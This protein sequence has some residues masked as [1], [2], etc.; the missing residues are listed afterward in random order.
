MSKL[1]LIT[2]GA[3]SGKSSFAL[4]LAKSLKGK[5]IYIA[6]ALPLDSEMRRRISLHKKARHK[7]WVTIE[8]PIDILSAIK[9]IRGKSS[10]IILDCLTLLLSNLML[11]GFN[12]KAIFNKIKSIT[13]V[14]KDKANVSIVVTNEVGSGIVPDNDLARRF[15]DLQGHANQIVNERADLVYLLVSGIPVRIKGEG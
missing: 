12:D 8:E 6:T 3:R 14:L 2:G 4:K 5:I 1:I 13:K 15:R 7:D 9:K 10:V 11:R